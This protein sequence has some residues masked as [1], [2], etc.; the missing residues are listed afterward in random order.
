LPNTDKI[1]GQIKVHRLKDRK[2][3]NEISL[4]GKQKHIKRKERDKKQ[5]Y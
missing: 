1:I 2:I 4:K 5:E 3:C